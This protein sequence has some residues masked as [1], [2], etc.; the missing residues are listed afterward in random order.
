MLLQPLTRRQL[1]FSFTID[2]NNHAPMMKKGCFMHRNTPPPPPPL[3]S[4]SPSFTPPKPPSPAMTN[5]R[6]AVA[7][8]AIQPAPLSSAPT[9]CLSGCP[10]VTTAAF[11]YGVKW[12]VKECYGCSYLPMQN[13]SLL[14]W[15]IRGQRGNQPLFVETNRSKAIETTLM[16]LVY[17]TEQKN[18]SLFLRWNL[19]RNMLTSLRI[20]I[21]MMLFKQMVA[22]LPARE[23]RLRETQ[24]LAPKPCGYTVQLNYVL[25]STFST[26]VP[27]WV[28]FP[29]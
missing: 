13:V 15:K 14:G 24:T 12:G 16:L 28:C 10:R 6:W 27:G 21:C 4:S 9:E 20:M 1:A 19:Q 22:V 7:L 23:I 17:I 29:A 18:W 26:S 25:Y 3:P 5:W 8:A 2:G 11:Y